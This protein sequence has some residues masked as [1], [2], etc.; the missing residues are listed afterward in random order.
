[1]LKVGLTGGIGS[2]KSTVAEYFSQLG[3]EIIDAD[4]LA[5]E[6]T[7]P[8]AAGFKA[9][10]ELFGSNILSVSGEIDRKKLRQIIF[11]DPLAKKHLERILHP[12]IIKKIIV[13]T[14]LLT[15]PYCIIV[16]PL[17]VETGFASKDFL[18]RI[19]VVDTSESLQ[20]ERASRRDSTSP[21]EILKIIK[22]QC[23]REERLRAADDIIVNN[24]DL[25]SLENQIKKLHHQYLQMSPG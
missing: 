18:D 12:L 13:K 21:Q 6:L 14:Q 19:C 23:S 8:T 16:I 3:T 17:L 10:I 11:H 5:R 4:H 1:M 2:G 24:N 15:V 7:V 9:I 20:I 25:V 22:D